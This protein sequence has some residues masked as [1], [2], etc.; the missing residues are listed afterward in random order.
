MPTVTTL[1][2]L[3]RRGLLAIGSGVLLSAT[4]LLAQPPRRT[5][6]GVELPLGPATVSPESLR[7]VAEQLKLLQGANLD[8]KLVSDVLKL[9]AQHPNLSNRELADKLLSDH[10]E[11]RDGKQQEALKQWLRQFG[12]EPGENGPFGG[13]AFPWPPN[14]PPGAQ[15]PVPPAGGR[16]GPGERTPGRFGPPPP[17]PIPQRGNPGR[18]G[19]GVRPP[20]ESRPGRPFEMRNGMNDQFPP[21]R[22][23]N[24]DNEVSAETLERRQKQFQAVAGWWE[25]NVGPM[26]ET[27]ALRQLLMDMFTGQSG[28]GE[29]T[30]SL[31]EL[32]EG[33]A[34]EGFGKIADR[35]GGSS[36]KLPKFGLGDGP[37]DSNFTP[38]PPPPSGSSFGGL[39]GF[40]GG[41]GS[42]LPV[43]ALLV[44]AAVGLVLWWLWPKLMARGEAVPR[45]LPGLGPWPVDPRHITDREAL[46]KAFEYLSVLVCGGGARTWNHVTIASALERAVPQA[47]ALADPLA[48]LYAVARYT[49]ADEPLPPGAVA[50]AREYLCELAGV[51]AA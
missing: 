36:F 51:P 7:Q 35:L 41:A 25:N 26:D 11:L 31:G 48:R 16:P 22:P 43:V 19:G 2:S 6:P 45:P 4:A 24:W 5:G 9:K 33:P 28:S 14:R 20:P 37:G 29:D 30:G 39:G 50:E 8:P 40:S 1:R 17:Q 49:P 15:P 44:V 21:P 34:G 13:G 12:V 10:P 46:V 38:P 47:E 23:Q 42:W 18:N 27:P 3:S 32:L